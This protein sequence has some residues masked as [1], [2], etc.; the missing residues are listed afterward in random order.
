MI[1]IDNYIYLEKFLSIEDKK[2]LREVNKIL[3]NVFYIEK[4]KIDI[5]NK[6]YQKHKDYCKN[7]FC[8]NNRNIEI[9]N[10]FPELSI[11][12]HPFILNKLNKLDITI[13]GVNVI[14]DNVEDNVED[15]INYERE[16]CE[17]C[18]NKYRVNIF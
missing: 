5:I 6:K 2:K 4:I 13:W 8:E 14:Q 3:K 17:E 10:L 1:G 12:K 7:I 16:Y 9:S 15:N 18:I 11:S